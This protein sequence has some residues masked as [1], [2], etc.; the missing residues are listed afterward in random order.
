ML[1]ELRSLW[2]GLPLLLVA[3]QYAPSKVFPGVNVRISDDLR[4]IV[5]FLGTKDDTPGSSGIHCKGTAFLAGFEGY[6][7]FVTVKHVALGLGDAPFRARFNK[8]NG[9]SRNID[10]DVGEIRWFLHP[11][12]DVDLAAVPFHFELKDQDI[13]AVFGAGLE[14][15]TSQIGYKCGDLCYTIGLFQLLAGKKRNLPVVHSGTIALLPSDEK[16]PVRDWEQP[17]DPAARK[18]VEGYLVQQESIQGLSGA[19][20]F[21]RSYVEISDIPVPGGRVPVLW[22]QTNVNLMGIW[23]GAWDAKADAIRATTLGYELRV[24][25]GMGVVIPAYKL[26]ELLQMPEVK[27]ERDNSK[28][29]WGD[30]PAKLDSVPSSDVSD[31]DA[32]PRHLEDFKRLVDVAARKRPQGDQT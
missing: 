8:T 21:G 4:R 10:I 32:N 5:F 12:P 11:D 9:E 6:G 28:K 19:P 15:I 23:Q 25:V 22:P 30:T 1:P 17:H 20:V 13:D 2:D 3:P 16:I 31:A 26:V 14:Q 27:R 7:Y 18:F 29:S 24:P